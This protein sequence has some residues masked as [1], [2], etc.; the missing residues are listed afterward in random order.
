M[1]ISIMSDIAER[2]VSLSGLNNLDRTESSM[3]LIHYPPASAIPENEEI[4]IGM[5]PHTDYGFFTFL[6]ADQPGLE[7][8]HFGE[9]KWIPVPLVQGFIVNVGDALSDATG[10]IFMS[11]P[12]RVIGNSKPRISIPF[13]Y[14]PARDYLVQE[15]GGPQI[16]YGEYIDQKYAQSYPNTN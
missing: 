12:H 9:E 8:W 1:Y 10:G 11:T 3:R 15:E 6:T 16:T 13:F 14:E 7:V 2:F 4:G 5:G